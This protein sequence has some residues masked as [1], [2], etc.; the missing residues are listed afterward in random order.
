MRVMELGRDRD[1]RVGMEMVEVM[2]R[3]VWNLRCDLL[4]WEV[5]MRGL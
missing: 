5:C 4:G 3:S 1:N 2:L